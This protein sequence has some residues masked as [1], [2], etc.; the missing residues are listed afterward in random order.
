MTANTPDNVG[1]TIKGNSKRQQILVIARKIIDEQ[2]YQ[3]LSFNHIASQLEVRKS[4]VQYYFPSK[5]SLM[6]A[7]IDEA[8]NYTDKDLF[9][10]EADLDIDPE[11]TF[12]RYVSDCVGSLFKSSDRNFFRNLFWL[13]TYDDK[14]ADDVKQ[15]YKAYIDDLT[16]LI[17]LL[18][19]YISIEECRAKATIIVSLYEGLGVVVDTDLQLSTSQKL[20]EATHQSAL[21]IAKQA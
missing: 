15:L 6:N 21:M 5:Q 13:A 18:N 11:K 14:I 2:G 1:K 12:M 20:I 4:N 17:T 19:P 9:R 7:L 10:G 16:R 8:R 3:E